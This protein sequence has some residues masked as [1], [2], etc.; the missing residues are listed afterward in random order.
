MK[1][2]WTKDFPKQ[3]GWY[4]VRFK[5][6]HGWRVIPGYIER[7]DRMKL[8]NVG[9]DLFFKGPHHEDQ[10]KRYKMSFGPKIEAPE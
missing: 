5:G 2:K 1:A 3:E 4:W 9:N 7:M 10:F 6:K 8:V